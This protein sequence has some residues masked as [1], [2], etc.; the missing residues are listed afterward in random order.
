M[1]LF[2]YSKNWNE[3]EYFDEVNA[4]KFYDY[5]ISLVNLIDVNEDN[6]DVR[7]FIGDYSKEMVKVT[8]NIKNGVVFEREQ[9]QIW[10]CGNCGFHIESKCAPEICPICSHPKSYFE[11]ENENY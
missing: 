10:E 2:D 1:N 9:A 5:R 6:Q 11:I 8:E 7:N 3:K 4:S